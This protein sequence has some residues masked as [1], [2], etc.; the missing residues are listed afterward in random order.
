MT[1]VL[2]VDDEEW[3]CR[4]VTERLSREPGFDVMYVTTGAAAQA[5][6]RAAP[7]PFDIFLLDLNLGDEDGI[8]L[9]RMLR[10]ISP[11]SDAVILTGHDD[12]GVSGLRAYEAGAY[13]YL[14]K[15]TQ[16]QELVWVLKS[17]EGHRSVRRERDWLGV[18]AGLSEDASSAVTV[19]AVAR[20]V[21]QA[22]R[23]L[24]FERARLWQFDADTQHLVGLA[25][26]GGVGLEGFAGFVV[27][28]ADSPYATESL[29]SRWP[30]TFYGRSHGPTALDHAFG[31]R[32]FLPP[33]GEW[34]DLPLWL[35]DQCLGLVTLD[36]ATRETWIHPDDRKLLGLFAEHSA[37][38]L[39]Q[40]REWETEQADSARHLLESRQHAGDLDLLHRVLDQALVPGADAQ[41]VVTA[42]V[43]ACQGMLADP[44]VEPCVLLREWQLGPDQ[45]AYVETR[46]Q[47]WL[48]NNT[49]ADG[50]ATDGRT[51]AAGL[52]AVD[53]AMEHDGERLGELRLVHSADH[54]VDEGTRFRL[55]RLAKAG[56]LA[57][58][59]VKRQ[60]QLALAVELSSAVT[61]AQGLAGGLTAVMRAVPQIAPGMSPLT[62]WYRDPVTR[63]VRR[64]PWFNV[65]WHAALGHDL[66]DPDSPVLWLMQAGEPIWAT[67]IR[68]VPRLSGPFAQREGV[69]SCA[70]LPLCADNEVVGAVFFNYRQSHAWSRDDRQFLQF[71]AQILA[72]SVRDAA[73]LDGAEA[74]RR[75]LE[76]AL[77]VAGSV[78]TTLDLNGTLEKILKALH[79]IFED[80]A[81]AILTY[82]ADRHELRF[83]PA[84]LGYYVLAPQP[85]GALPAFG[86][87]GPGI[88]SRLAQVALDSGRIVKDNTG[89]VLA[90]PMY[91]ALNPATRSQLTITLMSESKLMGVLLLESPEHD[92]FQDDD[93]RIVESVAPQVSTAIDR[94]RKSERLERMAGAAAIMGW[95]ANVAHELSRQVAGI[96]NRTYWIAAAP[97]ASDEVSAWAR[98]IDGMCAE[99]LSSVPAFAGNAGTGPV[100]LDPWLEE[101][102]TRLL[103]QRRPQ[104]DIQ[105]VFDL[106]CPD[107]AADVPTGLLRQVVLYLVRHAIAATAA[108]ATPDDPVYVAIRTRRVKRNDVEVQFEHPVFTV[109]GGPAANGNG[110]IATVAAPQQD[111]DYLILEALVE[112]TMHGAV[113]VHPGSAGGT[114]VF[115]LALPVANPD[116]V[117]R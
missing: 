27:P 67:D 1:R 74:G 84:C 96:R 63:H 80:T 82:S 103:Q 24:G 68:Q 12:A 19:M 88:C 13:R 104:H 66:A 108:R 57:L 38:L 70:A 46:R 3:S 65:R 30:T 101:T 93:V 20:L 114:V 35:R 45:Q 43:R 37:S 71:L 73:R 105:L 5:L 75:Q 23:R 86:V 6:V 32:G 29:A 49:L 41:D 53:I 48:S 40:A 111:V 112:N 85:G 115:D 2:V 33:V 11:T 4:I 44:E 116:V 72:V 69:K 87:D 21:V 76:A 109:A 97:G 51:A 9:L 52:L 62:V 26:D 64:G 95:T 31:S 7:Q 39:W 78:G 100:V 102:V 113:K 47:Y 91:Y 54:M 18:L 83:E 15:T 77:E 17:L 34:A 89:N 22:G 50:P 117:A 59:N 92:R 28:L 14:L 16:P 79:G 55:D 10:A 90:D 25:E 98:E 58:V 107:V 99:L 110:G 61:G 42:L 56:A 106:D 36:N 60:Q 8:E 94:A 81:I